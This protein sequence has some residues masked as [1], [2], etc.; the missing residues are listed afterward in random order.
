MAEEENALDF[1][2][3]DPTIK[4]GK[5]FGIMG[6]LLGSFLVLFSIT[7][8]FVSYPRAY[9]GL[10]IMTA[11]GNSVMA[12]CCGILVLVGLAHQFCREEFYTSSGE[13][14][15]DPNFINE[16]PEYN[17][18]IIVQCKPG[19]A[20]YCAIVAFFLFI[21][22]G[23]SLL[24]QSNSCSG[25]PV[26]PRHLRDQ[27]SP[28]KSVDRKLR[29]PDVIIEILDNGDGT[30]TKTTTKT[31]YNAAGSKQVEKTVEN[32]AGFLAAGNS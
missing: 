24:V 17:T 13:F 21:G 30:K 31:V 9:R 10:I 12:C 4:T 32:F 11:V 23:V 3:D 25:K 26:A 8:T 29:T 19:A 1:I 14:G 28:G 5:A 20:G 22:A 2:I 16:N 18:N 27:Q 7:F 15:Y 6:T